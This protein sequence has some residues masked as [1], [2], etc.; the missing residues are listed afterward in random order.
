VDAFYIRLAEITGREV[1]EVREDA[2]QGRMLTAEQARD[3][4]LIHE[5]AGTPPPRP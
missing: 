1:D 5:I 4:G 2:R 3:Y